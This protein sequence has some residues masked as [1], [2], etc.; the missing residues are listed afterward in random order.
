MGWFSSLVGGVV[1]FFVGGPVGAAIGAGLGATKA[2]EK[3]VNTL[4]DFVVQPFMGILGIPDIPKNNETERQQGVLVTRRAGGATDIPVVYGQRKVGGIITYAE[5]GPASSTPANKYLWVVYV[6]SEGPVEGLYE[7]Y[8]DDNQI[9]SKYIPQLNSGNL[10]TISDGKYANRVQMIYSKGQYYGAASASPVGTTLKNGLFKDCPRFTNRMVH[11]GLS[12]LFVRYEWLEVKTQEEANANPFSGS[13]PD[14]GAVL[15]G[16]RVASLVTT[17]SESYEHGAVGYTERYSTNPAEILLDYLR[18][19]R[20]G[21]GMKNS[22]IDWDSWRIAAAKCNTEVNY[23]KNETIRGPILTCNYVLDTSYTIF[24]NT[25]ILLQ[26]FRAYMPYVQGRYKLKI[27]DAGN[28]TNILSGAATIVAECVGSSQIIDASVLENRYE[29]MG[30]VVYT[31]ID[32]S[33]KYNQVVVTY[34]DPR[35]EYKW[36]TQQMVYPES[37]S[38]RLVYVAQ[39]GGR[40]NKLEITMPTITNFAIAYDFARILFNKSRY[41]ESATL[42]VSSHA[43]ELE[44]GDNIRIQNRILNFG[45]VPW[46]VVA[47][48]HNDDYTFDIACVRNP[49]FIYPYTAVG[50]P[51]RVLPVYVPKGATV[52]YP[53]EIDRP[54]GALIPPTNSSGGGGAIGNPEPTVPTGPAG[55]GIGLPDGSNNTLGTNNAPKPAPELQP[56]T[57]VIDV[58][59]V[60]YTLNNG[61]LYGRV[62]FVQPPNALFAGVDFYF[63][64]AGRTADVFQIIQDRQTRGSGQLLSVLIGPLANISSLNAQFNQ[65]DVFARVVY[66]TGELSQDFVRFQLDPASAPGSIATIGEIRQSTLQSSQAWPVSVAPPASRR[67]NAIERDSA[68][69]L[70]PVPQANLRTMTF[71]ITQDVLAEGANFDVVGFNVYSKPASVT[72]YTLSRHTFAAGY[73][74]GFLVN[75]PF[76]G[77]IGTA[78]QDSEYDLVIRLVYRDDRESS[79]QFY[80]RISVERPPGSANPT[81]AL[82]GRQRTV[83]A[84]TARSVITTNQAPPGAIGDP[85]QLRL[86][87]D[88]LSAVGTDNG[89]A[90]T[91]TPPSESDRPFWSGTRIYYRP[92]LPGTNPAHERVDSYQTQIVGGL[93]PSIRVPL[94]HGVRYEMIVVAL[95]LVGGQIVES[96]RAL[97]GTGLVT[98]NVLD[99]NYSQQTNGNWAAS[100]AFELTTTTQAMRRIGNPFEGDP[101]PVVNVQKLFSFSDYNLYLDIGASRRISDYI[102]LTYDTGDIPN[103][104]RLRIYRRTIGSNPGVGSPIANYWGVGRWDRVDVTGTGVQTV[105]LRLPVNYTEFNRWYERVRPWNEDDQGTGLYRTTNPPGL[106]PITNFIREVQLLLQIELTTGVSTDA[107]L[108]TFQGF[109]GQLDY[110]D[111]LQ[112]RPIP[113]RIAVQSTFNIRDSD[114]LPGYDRRLSEARTTDIP[115]TSRSYGG[116]WATIPG[117]FSAPY[118]LVDG[119]P[120]VRTGPAIV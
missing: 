105:N 23:L 59:N 14:I 16:R 112:G 44:P 46:R 13:I 83:E 54:D 87:I 6:L 50:Q 113:Q 79:R 72:Y 35:T 71:R 110:Q 11:N 94:R 33:N 52:Y 100:W 101:N 26:G 115:Y 81:N 92:V 57:D 45:N 73:V 31:G 40:E 66:T 116:G 34:V 9:D 93:L 84:T 22:E 99:R 20:Y 102:E 108:C 68:E 48:Q 117:R 107:I 98:N 47:I 17:A 109:T 119:Y 76:T 104:S 12:C 91:L 70:I 36:S 41:A 1:G 55:G 88:F 29:I 19:P 5:T 120:P 8:I 106:I 74:P 37:E 63:A 80:T 51:D 97:F 95:V 3:V 25:K 67:D 39:D 10:V 56:L 78:G 24:Q 7:L 27:E 64:S 21:K 15:L 77:S 114:F 89:A 62:I 82:F 32:R 38:E 85:T 28:P 111:Q 30:D 18:H 65:V 2:G 58:I 43:F 49:D 4:V 61:L 42:R 90:V 75:T 53:V 118:P 103:F 86:G 69:I 60:T 96:T